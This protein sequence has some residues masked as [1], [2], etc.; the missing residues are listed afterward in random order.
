M[1]IRTF[2]VTISFSNDSW[3]IIK[4]C[5]STAETRSVTK[6]QGTGIIYSL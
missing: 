3:Q 2:M 1:P 5:M 6:A 4:K